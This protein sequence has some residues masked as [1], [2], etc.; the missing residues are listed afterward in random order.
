MDLSK[1]VMD[2][3]KFSLKIDN[4][5]GKKAAKKVLNEK[6]SKNNRRNCDCLK[7]TL[8]VQT[9]CCLLV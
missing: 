2:F 4:A 8:S 7:F 3:G 9:I 6:E 5:E 1:E